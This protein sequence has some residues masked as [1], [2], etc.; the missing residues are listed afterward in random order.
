M[1]VAIDGL[2]TRMGEHRLRASPTGY[3]GLERW[4]IGMGDIVA[5]GVEG[6]GSFGAG[7]ARFLSTR[8]HTVIEVSRPDR[9]TRR[10]LGK[11]DPILPRK[12]AAARAVLAGALYENVNPA[13]TLYYVA[14]LY[15]LSA[16]VLV[17]TNFKP[18]EPADGRE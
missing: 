1:A 3:A 16:L 10:R 17:T 14:G 5:F 18:A 2:G 12:E 7:L 11:S 8:G 4:A 15:G 9:S 13:A 6:T